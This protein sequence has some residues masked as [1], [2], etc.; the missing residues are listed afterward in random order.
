MEKY[1][2]IG[3]TGVMGHYVTRQ[4]VAMGHMPVVVTVSGNTT[5]I[6]DL[7]NEKLQCDTDK[8]NNFKPC[9]LM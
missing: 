6:N 4:L 9:S 3:G 7:I 8:I 2:L 5:F 1:L